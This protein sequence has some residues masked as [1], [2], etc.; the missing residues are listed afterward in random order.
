MFD[1]K[2]A[3]LQEEQKRQTGLATRSSF[4]EQTR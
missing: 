3:G 4:N 1:L 2:K